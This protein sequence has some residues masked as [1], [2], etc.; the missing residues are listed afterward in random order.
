MPNLPLHAF[1]LV[2]IAAAIAAAANPLPLAAPPPSILAAARGLPTPAAA[3]QS[4]STAPAPSAP[5]L[6]TPVVA[7]A[8]AAAPVPEP[9]QAQR[10]GL[11]DP[12]LAALLSS[13]RA[14]RLEG[15]YPRAVDHF[16]AAVAR[17]GGP[18]ASWRLGEALLADGRARAAAEVLDAAVKNAPPGP[19]RQAAL[20]LLGRARLAQGE[21]R[22]ALAAFREYTAEPNPLG[23][24]AHL[25]TADAAHALER[26]E[27]AAREA[28]LAAGDAASRRLRI[29]AMERLAR[30]AEE[31]GDPAAAADWYR[32]VADLTTSR[33]F[34]ADM[35]YELA[36]LE[37]QLGRHDDAVRHLTELATQQPVPRRAA[38]AL[39]DLVLMGADAAVDDYQAGLVRLAN[40][41][42]ALAIANFD[43]FLAGNPAPAA[44]AEAH[45]QRALARAHLGDDAAA[46]A[47]LEQIAATYPDTPAAPRAL[48]RAG[49]WMEIDG[50]F[51]RAAAYYARLVASYPAAPERA[52]ARF[53]QGLAL[54]RAGQA[55]E[56]QAIW[57]ELAQ[58]PPRGPQTAETLLWLGKLLAQ[59]G[60]SAGARARWREAA[61]VDP[62]GY[63]GLRA[64]A[65]LGELGPSPSDLTTIAPPPRDAA[66][67][68]WLRAHDPEGRAE[69]AVRGDPAFRRGL[70]LADMG[71]RD[72]ASWEL[73]DLVTRWQGDRARLYFL[74]RGAAEAGLFDVALSAGARL[75][76]A[77]SAALPRGVLQ[78]VYPLPFPR[79]V[80]EA[81]ARER[82]DPLLLVA[83]M[84][85]ESAF[86]PLATSSAQARGLTQVIPPTAREL[87]DDLGVADFAQEDLYKPYVSIP[88]GARYLADRLREYDGQLLPALAAYNAGSGNVRR[89][90]RLPGADDAD[91][92]LAQ[93][94]FSETSNYV[95]RVYT[96]YRLYQSIYGA[97]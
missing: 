42:Y 45:F 19:D 96:Y 9:L 61:G 52:E 60:D 46:L 68:A 28:E 29:E 24:Y 25:L 69:E 92:F 85:Q 62:T 87:A 15:D 31:R 49:R 2:A 5:D 93:I 90:L 20:L 94:P 33:E 91:L 26:Y 32:R 17:G 51:S 14:A 77:G 4:A 43:R 54:Y 95:R 13:G 63:F 41:Q 88:F 58:E 38:A 97:G 44:A 81:A 67:E 79:L 72:E 16:A 70:A 37:R 66:L 36:R 40:Q 73:A 83:L 18:E 75:L 21:Y 64:R 30:L 39:D 22:A 27:L 89:W 74:A 59:R 35:L 11:A 7:E 76:D 80:S 57:S 1:T 78:L 34:R 47:D 82:L 55:A 65:L 3:A 48:L 8:T 50:D 86:N 6:P 10:T 56:A 84:R 71:M 53:R 23:P 12:A